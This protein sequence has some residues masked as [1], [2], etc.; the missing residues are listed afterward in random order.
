VTSF[1]HALL[2]LVSLGLLAF[3]FLLLE[4]GD[5]FPYLLMGAGC[6]AMG[7]AVSALSA[8]FSG[9][10]SIRNPLLFAG[11]VLSVALLFPIGFLPRLGLPVLSW[12]GFGLAMWAASWAGGCAGTTLNKARQRKAS[13]VQTTIA[14]GSTT[15]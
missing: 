4:T 2:G 13:N 8:Y 5:W 11:P 14:T 7:A 10:R 15:R 6:C 1:L 12:Y 9:R 3:T